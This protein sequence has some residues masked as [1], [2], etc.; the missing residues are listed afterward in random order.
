MER[1]N[2]R[3][4]E[5]CARHSHAAGVGCIM[6]ISSD[7]I[8]ELHNIALPLDVELAAQDGRDSSCPLPTHLLVPNTE[9]WRIVVLKNNG[10][11][12]LFSVIIHNNETG[13][14]ILQRLRGQ[15]GISMVQQY[16]N[17]IFFFREQAIFVGKVSLVSDH[18][19]SD[20]KNLLT[21]SE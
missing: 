12:L 5:L 4:Y 15:F 20:W 19:R 7:T 11:G 6:P 18:A 17:K 21:V 13:A 14:G 16:L 9:L 8:M 1:S 10:V 3:I 2:I